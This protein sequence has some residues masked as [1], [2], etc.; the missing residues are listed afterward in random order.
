MEAVSDGTSDIQV[1]AV[2]NVLVEPSTVT[3]LF[4]IHH[5]DLP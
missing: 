3:V 4:N 5:K 2:G 1:L